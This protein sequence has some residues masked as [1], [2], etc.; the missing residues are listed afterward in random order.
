[1]LQRAYEG[2]SLKDGWRPKR[3]GAS[4]NTDHL[5]DGATLRARARSLVQ[6]VPYI[7]C[8][9]EALVS[10]TIGTGIVPRSLSS[11]AAVIDELWDE[12][13]KVADA[14]G[15]CD[16]YG[17]QALAYR[18]MEQDGE[19][20]IRLRARRPE[21]GLPVPCNSKSWKSTGS[22]TPGWAAMVQTSS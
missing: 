18:A 13:G 12:W 20:L 22:I 5:A 15:H 16:I 8:G 14:D 1:M 11:N 7:A 10:N 21:D 6:N 3:S 17:L 19:V 9:L 2:A 4:A